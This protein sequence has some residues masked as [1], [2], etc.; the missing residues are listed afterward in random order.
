MYTFCM[1]HIVARKCRSV[2]L[3]I[4]E[5]KKWDQQ[6]SAFLCTYAEMQCCQSIAE[7]EIHST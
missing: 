3:D 2:R 7:N 6:W 1:I 4:Y 5:V